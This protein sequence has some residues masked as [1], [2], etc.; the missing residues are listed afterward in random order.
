MPTPA[1]STTIMYGN[2][3][4]VVS[5]EQRD[6]LVE[7]RVIEWNHTLQVW[8]PQKDEDNVREPNWDRA[9]RYLDASI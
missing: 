7:S 2:R 9:M 1:E 5:F 3:S 4:V 8:Y 6:A